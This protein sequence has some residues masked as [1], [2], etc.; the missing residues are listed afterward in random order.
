MWRSLSSGKKSEQKL[1]FMDITQAINQ[2][3][4]TRLSLHSYIPLCYE[5]TLA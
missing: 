2:L 4:N 5:S 3:S 1:E